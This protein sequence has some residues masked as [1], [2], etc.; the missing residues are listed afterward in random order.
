MSFVAIDLGASGTRYVSESGEIGVLPNN[1]VYVERAWESDMEPY[2]SDLKSALDVTIESD[3]GSEY[4]PVHILAGQMA[5]RYSAANQRPSV[6]LNKCKQRINFIS[7]VLAAAVSVIENGTKD[8]IDLYLALPPIEIK[9]AKELVSSQLK[10]T[11][12]VTFHK[13]AVT[14]SFKISN[15]EMYEE[16]FMAILAY[17]FNE[18][19]TLKEAS[20]K[21]ADGAI[22]SMDIGASTTDLAVVRNMRYMDKSGQTYKTGGNIA[23][24]ILADYIR[25][26]YGYDAPADILD[27]AIKEGRLRMGNGYVDCAEAVNNAKQILADKIV[28]QIQA[29]FVK[30]GIPIHTIRA[31][32]VSGGGS[33]EGAYEDN[34]GELIFTGRPVSYFITKALQSICPGVEVEQFP[35]NPRMANIQGLYIRAGLEIR[36]KKREEELRRAK[37]SSE[38]AETANMGEAPE[39]R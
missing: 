9:T 37:A 25:G 31:V 34:T 8:D 2:S 35:G 20:K 18:D 29:Y 26:M 13:K 1:M 7:A 24:D 11:Y 36:R 27:E 16:S 17:F 38:S 22:L 5:E 28:E 30:I 21:Y 3:N 12:T 10:G 33:M 23:R 15:V 6:L 19:G 14:V 32:V 39:N 4:F